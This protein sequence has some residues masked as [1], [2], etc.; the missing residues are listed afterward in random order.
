[1]IKSKDLYMKSIYDL[2]GKKIGTS[3]EIFIDFNK[4]MVLGLEINT[5][6][7][8]NNYVDINDIIQIDKDILIRKVSEVRG[9]RFTEIKNMEVKD[10]CGNSKGVIEDLLIDDDNYNIKGLIVNSGIFDTLI[11]GK[12]VILINNSILGEEY[13]L[14]LGEPNI[15]FK[16]I[17]HEL[18]N[19][20][21][22]KK[23]Y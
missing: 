4:G 5:L 21:N 22:L 3:K 14:Y 13:I 19:N 8:K 2:N 1:M 11:K 20:E 6:G 17:P 15:V 23:A 9:L 10:K 7:F 16:N 18:E 12:E